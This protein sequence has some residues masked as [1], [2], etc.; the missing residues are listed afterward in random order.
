MDRNGRKCVWVGTLPFAAPDGAAFL[1]RLLQG[2]DLLGVAL[3]ELVVEIK[4]LLHL[5]HQVRIG[6]GLEFFVGGG[7]AVGQEVELRVDVSLQ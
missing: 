2:V 6:E 5:V 4:L 3:E 7:E 1:L